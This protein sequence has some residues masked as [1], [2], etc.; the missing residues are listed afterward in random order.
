[1]EMV[2][3]QMKNTLLLVFW[4]IMLMYVFHVLIF[5]VLYLHP[6]SPLDP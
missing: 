5:H 3:Q 2:L 4:L 1:M 6:R